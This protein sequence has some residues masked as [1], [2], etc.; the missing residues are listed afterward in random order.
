[1]KPLYIGK[2]S[3]EECRNLPKSKCYHSNIHFQESVYD[4]SK[5]NVLFSM[6]EESS[7]FLA[8]EETFFC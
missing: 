5:C 2:F 6:D 7:T 3:E 1:M 8:S 4:V